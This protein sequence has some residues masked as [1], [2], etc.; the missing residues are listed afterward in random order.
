[1]NRDPNTQRQ[2]ASMHRRRV[3]LDFSPFQAGLD[4]LGQA[5]L[6]FLCE[7][8]AMAPMTELRDR[9]AA[10]DVSAVEL[11]LGYVARIRR[12]DDALQSMLALNPDAL[13][14]ARQSDEA[15]RAGQ[16]DGVLHGLPILLKDNID[17]APPVPTTAGAGALMG[18]V[19]AQD[20]FLVR[21]LADA[22]AIILGKTNL[23]E[24]AFWMSDAGA[25]GYSYVG[26]QTRNPHGR[27]DVGGSSSGSGA[28]VAAGFGA[29]AIGTETSGSISSPTS[30]NGLA[31]LKPS[32]GLVSRTGV[33]PIVD[34]LDTPGPMTRTVADTALLLSALAAHDPADPEAGH[35]ALRPLFG[36]DF[37]ADIQP[38]ALRG[39]RVG[40]MRYDMRLPG[41]TNLI[42]TEIRALVGMLAARMRVI[43]L[44][45]ER[46]GALPVPLPP[47]HLQPDGWDLPA[48]LSAGFRD[49]LDAYL[50]GRPDLPPHARTLAHII[51]WNDQNLPERAPYNQAKLVESQASPYDPAG[52]RALG[53]EMRAAADQFLTGLMTRHDVACVASVGS[54]ASMYYAAAGWP[55]VCV[56]VGR[57]AR[58]GERFNAT[59]FG[60]HASEPRLI[61][62]GAA[63]ERAV[64]R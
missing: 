3:R 51:A 40:I 11:V 7:L 32:I 22:G 33:V 57:V 59:L 55:A 35:T 31:G 47:L 14:Q 52:Y 48:V 26:G 53:L 15:R 27:Y 37:L 19:A 25:S 10:G 50:A 36:R 62:Y 45:L 8:L 64:T 49:Q 13:A 24:W 6:D 9:L 42:S 18:T 63:L 58:T 41:A 38:D 34:V 29:A 60:P 12:H 39:V 54:Y 56:P 43:R 16:A 30:A 17:T 44:A 1:M 61:G 5:R 21:R 20:A 46:A 4:G 23:S 2:L 28:A